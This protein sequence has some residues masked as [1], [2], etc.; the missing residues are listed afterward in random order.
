MKTHTSHSRISVMGAGVIGRRHIEHIVAEP[1]V[2]L[3]SIID[4]TEAG[5]VLATSVNTPW[6]ADFASMVAAGKPDGILIATPNQMHVQHGLDAIAARIPT[7]VEKPLS[8]NLRAGQRMVEA[9]EKA[10]VPLLTGHHRRHN[11]MVKRAKQIIES[12]KLGKIITAHSFFWLLKPDDYFEQEWRRKKGAGPVM[13][14]M[15]HDIDL[16]RHFCGEVEIVQALQSNAV[17]GFEVNETTVVS[18][19]F[20]SGTLGTL[21]V[22]DTV[23]APWSWEHTTGENQHYPRTDQLCYMLGGT[24]GSLSIPR[25][26]VWTN[27]TKPSWWEPFKVERIIAAD[28]DPLRLQIQQFSKVIQG[29]E[30][31]LVSGREGLMTLK[32]IDAIQRAAESGKMIR[33]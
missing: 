12:G 28:L 21:S 27:E 10:D 19:R 7:L 16:L 30:K 3:H 33:L 9:A 15:S 31:P 20:T 1:S 8:D 32:V 6:F 29:T 18:L 23:V 22:S 14:N 13:M 25:L 2:L 26:D 5:R 4:P 11:P 17:R 24:K